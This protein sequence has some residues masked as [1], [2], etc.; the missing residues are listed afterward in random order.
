MKMIK[1]LASAAILLAVLTG[2]ESLEKVK[3]YGNGDIVAPVM[4][5]MQPVTINTD[6]LETGTLTF[7]WAPADFGYD[8]MVSYSIYAT[9]GDKTDYVLYEEIHQPNYEIANSA[10]YTKLTGSSYMGLP[11]DQNVTLSIYVTATIGSNYDVVKSDPVTVDFYLAS[12]AGVPKLLK[13]SG[14]H[15]AWGGSFITGIWGVDELYSGYCDMNVS[16]GG[17]VEYKFVDNSGKWW[18][19][20]LGNLSTSGGNL[21][22]SAGLYYIK[23]DM[24]SKTASAVPMTKVGLTGINGSWRTPA[25]E[26][27]YDQAS[28]SYIWE[29]E[30]TSGSG[31]RVLCYSPTDAAGWYWSYTMSAATADDVVMVSGGKSKLVERGKHESGGDG[32]LSL[33]DTG[34]YK[35]TLYYDTKEHYFYLSAKKQ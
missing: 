22:T 1:S 29:G 35:F 25:V 3:A 32:N 30:V 18:G 15:N 14:S 8:A 26:M 21:S 13:I 17:N 7:S 19:G 23:A 4:N 11:T 10:L 20:E 9:G 34:K 27:T 28:R 31:F 12:I 2:C 24:N 5:T 6:N 16:G 33:N